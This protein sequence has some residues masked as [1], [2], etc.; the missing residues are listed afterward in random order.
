[1]SDGT[2][3]IENAQ[4]RELTADEI[5]LVSGGHPLLGPALDIL[6]GTSKNSS[7]RVPANLTR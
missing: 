6:K 2:P 1:M 3:G 5:G 4:S 7:R